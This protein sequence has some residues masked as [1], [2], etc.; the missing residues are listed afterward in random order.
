MR[1][2]FLLIFSLWYLE[3]KQHMYTH[4]HIYLYATIKIKEKEAFNLRVRGTEW[5][6]WTWEGL[7]RGKGKLEGL[8]YYFNLEMRNNLKQRATKI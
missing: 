7:E 3:N 5:V 6:V 2:A 4:R 8:W 1:I